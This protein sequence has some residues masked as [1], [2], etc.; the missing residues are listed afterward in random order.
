[1]VW[2]GFFCFEYENL[3]RIRLLV[4]L[5][6]GKPDLGFVGAVCQIPKGVD[7]SEKK[8]DKR[9][10]EKKKKKEEREREVCACVSQRGRD[11]Q[12]KDKSN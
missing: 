8:E 9:W 5:E 7:K 4:S 10:R 3:N 12:K 1:M 6:K 11:D 2:F